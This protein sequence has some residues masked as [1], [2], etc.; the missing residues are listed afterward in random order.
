MRLM[1]AAVV[2]E[3]DPIGGKA[4]EFRYGLIAPQSTSKMASPS[5]TPTARNSNFLIC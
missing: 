3:L 4:S 1:L 2:V 5:T